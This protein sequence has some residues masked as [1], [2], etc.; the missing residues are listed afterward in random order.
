MYWNGLSS[1]GVGWLS[2]ALTE[3]DDGVYAAMLVAYVV[4]EEVKHTGCSLHGVQH[5]ANADSLNND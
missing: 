2:V 5:T 1:G 3:C 4:D